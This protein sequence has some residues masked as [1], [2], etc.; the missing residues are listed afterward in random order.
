VK[1]DDYAGFT[2]QNNHAML[3]QQIQG[4]RYDTIYP[5]RFATR[6]ATYPFPGWK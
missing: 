3:V 5:P 2:N 4:G 6:K 1:F